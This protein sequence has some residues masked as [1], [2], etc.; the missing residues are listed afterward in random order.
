MIAS[1]S[2][3]QFLQSVI[4]R[5]VRPVNPSRFIQTHL[6]DL[7]EIS[8]QPEYCWPLFG[9]FLISLF[10]RDF[11]WLQVDNDW[12][13]QREEFETHLARLRAAVPG[14]SPAPETSAEAPPDL[15]VWHTRFHSATFFACLLPRLSV[16]VTL[17]NSWYM[18]PPFGPMHVVD[19]I[20]FIM[21]FRYFLISPPQSWICHNFFFKPRRWCG[22]YH[23]QQQV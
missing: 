7:I 23:V 11:V 9:L 14:C 16:F 4:W 1:L 12:W 10:S 17:R 18:M 3:S 2:V 6:S 15:E 22:V 8:H 5:L 19:L 13:S 21:L 20:I